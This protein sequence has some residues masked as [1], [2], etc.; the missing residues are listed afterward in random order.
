MN[1]LRFTVIE[2]RVVKIV[3]RANKTSK[4]GFDDGVRYD[5]SA[6]WFRFTERAFPSSRL[7]H[8]TGW[9]AKKLVR[10]YM[11]ISITRVGVYGLFAGS[12]L[13]ALWSPMAW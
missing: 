12:V 6:A 9:S 5:C 11:H 4:Y 10:R 7:R 1:L 13:S 8:S 3:F 2:C